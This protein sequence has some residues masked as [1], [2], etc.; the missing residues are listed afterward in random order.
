MWFVRCILYTASFQL[1]LH[2]SSHTVE[3]IRTPEGYCAQIVIKLQSDR[4]HVLCISELT[5][6]MGKAWTCPYGQ[7][8]AAVQSEC[9]HLREHNEFNKWT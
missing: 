3:I 4:V 1:I 7:R 2:V 9:T 6:C 5:W 8:L